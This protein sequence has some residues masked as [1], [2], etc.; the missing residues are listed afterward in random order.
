M[1][2]RTVFTKSIPL[3][4]I[5]TILM[6]FGMS[7]T[8]PM[9]PEELKSSIEI[10]DIDTRW[11]KKYYQPW[12]PKL[13]LVPAVSFKVKNIGEEPL[14]FVYFNGIFRFIGKKENLGDNFVT[15]INGDPLKPGETSEE[16]TLQSNFG[17]EGDNV[18]HFKNNPEW[19][20][21]EVR[22][23]AKS[24]GSQYILLEEHNISKKINFE[25]PEQVGLEEEEEKKK[26]KKKKNSLQ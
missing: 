5:L 20:Q 18:N 7:C 9:S 11:E 25:E 10:L 17:V 23:F 22:I 21:A 12:P 14:S 2:K 24:K 15:G 19:K 16:I 6:T 8:K 13:T 3:V 26:D 4:F 1:K